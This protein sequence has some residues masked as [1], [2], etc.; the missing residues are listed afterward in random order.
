M[1]EFRLRVPKWYPEKSRRREGDLV[2]PE[3]TDGA[4]NEKVLTIGEI[5]SRLDD[6]RGISNREG[7]AEGPRD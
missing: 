7:D 1:K 5:P 3:A 4:Q 2:L 6:F